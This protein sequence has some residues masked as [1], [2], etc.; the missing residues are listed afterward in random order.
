MKNKLKKFYNALEDF[1]EYFFSFGSAKKDYE[2]ITSIIKAQGFW[3]GTSYR[4]YF[5]NDL[6]LIKVEERW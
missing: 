1:G 5:D 2:Y 4:F 3:S 6:N